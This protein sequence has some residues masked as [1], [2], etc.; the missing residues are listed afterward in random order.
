MTVVHR[1]TAI[2]RPAERR[3]VPNSLSDPDLTDLPQ[4]DALGV[5]QTASVRKVVSEVVTGVGEEL[6]PVANLL[7][8]C[9]VVVVAEVGAEE[10]VGGDDV[11]G[12]V[13]VV[14][15]CCGQ[16]D[17]WV[18][19]PDE[20]GAGEADRVGFEPER[21]HVDLLLGERDEPVGHLAPADAG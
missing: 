20:F 15:G 9:C 12:A 21:G 19:E 14:G 11:V 7:Q 4:P 2:R 3:A 17:R 16:E 1:P 8:R 6:Q 18:G 10:R 5:E 13:R